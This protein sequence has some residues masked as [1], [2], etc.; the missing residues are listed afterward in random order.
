MRCD[1]IRTDGEAGRGVQKIWMLFESQDSVDTDETK[2]IGF[3]ISYMQH[4]V[5]LPFPLSLYQPFICTI[6]DEPFMINSLKMARINP[7]C[8]VCRSIMTEL[9]SLSQ[10]SLTCRLDVLTKR[11]VEKPLYRPKLILLNLYSFTFC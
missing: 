4:L 1:G 10:F 9:L 7:A 8:L 2:K 6:N 5:R 11:R 3:T